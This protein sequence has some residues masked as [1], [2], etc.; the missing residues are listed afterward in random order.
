MLAAVLRF[1]FLQNTVFSCKTKQTNPCS[2]FIFY[3]FVGCFDLLMI[4]A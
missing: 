4:L 1:R 3:E 2:V